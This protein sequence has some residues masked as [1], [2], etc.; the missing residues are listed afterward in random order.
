MN[1]KL[2]ILPAEWR[3]LRQTHL[4]ARRDLDDRN[5]E[6]RKKRIEKKA[7]KARVGLAAKVDD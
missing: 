4:A 2:V 1:L 7:G 3:K 6:A 5:F